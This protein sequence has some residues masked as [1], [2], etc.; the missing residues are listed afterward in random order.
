MGGFLGAGKTTLILAAARRLRSQ[1]FRPAIITN[2]QDR[3]LVDTRVAEANHFPAREVAGGCFCCRFS[4]LLDAAAQLKAF[5]PDV[6]FAE[7]VGSCVDLSATIL[8]PLKAYFRDDYGVAPLTV[9]VDPEMAG[10]V[11]TGAAD[12][13]VDFL[14][15]Q[16]LAEADLVCI[17]KADT[18]PAPALPLPVD[19]HVSALTGQGID[20]W[21]AEVLGGSRIAG[22]R[23]L[24]VDYARYAD[25][26]AAFGWVNVQAE[27]TLFRPASPAMLAG[28]L[29]DDL[30]SRLSQARIAIAHLKVF[31]GCPSGFVKVSV[32]RNGEEPQADGDLAA[33]SE[34]R[35]ELVI[36][37]RAAGD[38]ADL[39][40]IVRQAL[41]TVGGDIEIRHSGA[42][43]PAPPS[44]EHRFPNVVR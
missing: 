31:A 24:D 15:R 41:G 6:I 4:D 7:P 29:V 33:S 19:F 17:T 1:G 37:L 3:G 12:P 27:V 42:F 8:Q 14:F 22:A 2:D 13:N 28:P 16:Q 20:P 10:R 36:N 40:A 38:P 21:L 34:L 35:H 11:F 39:L 26:E 43:R 18:H 5:S 25:A 23:V 44:P 9:L 30:E 32:C